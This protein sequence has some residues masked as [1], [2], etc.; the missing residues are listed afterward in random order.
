[1]MLAWSNVIYGVG[2]GILLL[3]L[4][5]LGYFI[6]DRTILRHFTVSREI[7]HNNAAVALVV[8]GTFLAL[9]IALGLVLSIGLI[10]G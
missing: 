10:G 7:K 5:F 4:M 2:S 1:M 8:A 9:G 3:A 6:I